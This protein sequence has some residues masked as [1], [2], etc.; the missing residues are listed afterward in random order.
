M[1][2]LIEKLE[3]HMESRGQDTNIQIMELKQQS[4]TSFIV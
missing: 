3:K 1:D 2:I 4:M